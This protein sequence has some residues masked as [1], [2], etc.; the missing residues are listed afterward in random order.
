M[1]MTVSSLFVLMII[2]LMIN[3]VC[4]ALVASIDIGIQYTDE[5]ETICTTQHFP[6]AF[7]AN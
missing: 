1:T 3:N 7:H 4:R 2:C 5:T 6:I